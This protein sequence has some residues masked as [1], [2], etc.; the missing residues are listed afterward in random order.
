MPAAPKRRAAASPISVGCF[1]LWPDEGALRVGDRN[2]PLTR[3]EF[4][5]LHALVIR[6]GHVVLRTALYRD[7]W[8][9]EVPGHQDRSLDVY[10]R[11]LRQKLAAAA[12]AWR[13]IHTHVGVGYRFEPEPIS[14]PPTERKHS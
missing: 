14:D 2:L 12:P 9:V 3:R 5:V 10:I 6:R 8:G 7:I 13:T 11:R 4:Q 1:E